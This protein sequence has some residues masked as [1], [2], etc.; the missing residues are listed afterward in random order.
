MSA[1]GTGP[2]SGR[3]SG[4]HYKE[5]GHTC[6]AHCHGAGPAAVPGLSETFNKCFCFFLSDTQV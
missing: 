2:E 4:K 1:M 5:R 6:F 3:E